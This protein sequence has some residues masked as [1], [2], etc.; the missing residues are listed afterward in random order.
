[1]QQRKVFSDATDC[2]EDSEA[3]QND[4]GLP[5]YSD[6]KKA[7]KTLEKV[8][9]RTEVLTSKTLNELLGRRLNN[10]KGGKLEVFMKCENF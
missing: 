1:M 3:Q 9:H 4:D 6:V 7:A 5:R 8:A 10:G 2:S